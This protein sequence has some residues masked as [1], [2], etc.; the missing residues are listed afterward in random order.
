MALANYQNLKDSAIAW[1]H[2][3][4][5]DL[6]IDDFILLAEN[7]FYS[8]PVETLSLRVMEGQ[9]TAT[10]STSSRQV[11]LPADFLSN[12]RIR[13][14]LSTGDH[15]ELKYRAPEQM[16]IQGASGQPRYYTITDV[17]E[18]DRT[19]DTAYTVEFQYFKKIA[20]LTSE[21]TTND[22]LTNYPNIYLYGVLHQAFLYATDEVEAAKWQRKFI[23]AI[24]GANRKDKKGRFGTAPA[25]RI[26]GAT[27]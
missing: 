20:A 8:N 2:R 27:P 25:M 11:T 15:G 14:Q 18:F 21:A 7:E 26:E 12:R 23:S 22:I 13:L 10:A 17:L 16:V 1:S 6:L 5:L 24:K 4:D 3:A 9:A 19:P